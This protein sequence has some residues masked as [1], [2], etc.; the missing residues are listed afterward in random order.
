MIEA[1]FLVGRNC[2]ILMKPQSEDSFTFDKQPYLW[3]T[4]LYKSERHGGIET[5]HFFS[6]LLLFCDFTFFLIIFML[7]AAEMTAHHVEF[8]LSLQKKS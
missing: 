7:R 5:Q 6:F 1:D 2:I 3:L 8:I 4:I